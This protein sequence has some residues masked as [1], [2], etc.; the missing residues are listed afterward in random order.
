MWIEVS[1]MLPVHSIKLQAATLF[2]YN[3]AIRQRFLHDPPVKKDSGMLLPSK[4]KIAAEKTK[5]PLQITNI[6]PE[7]PRLGCGAKQQEF[8]LQACKQ[9][10]FR[11]GDPKAMVFPYI[12]VKWDPLIWPTNDAELSLTYTRTHVEKEMERQTE[13]ERRKQE[14][15][16]CHRGRSWTGEENQAEAAACFLQ[17]HLGLL[18]FLSRPQHTCEQYE[19]QYL[20][21]K[22]HMLNGALIEI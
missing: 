14:W 22:Y 15:W 3:L 12:G 16:W 1:C 2:Q 19:A 7:R 8:P 21:V 6:Q 10:A 5:K 18:R 9:V 20:C 4:R 17:V 13:K 11:E